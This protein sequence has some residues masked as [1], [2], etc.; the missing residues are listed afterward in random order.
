MSLVSN[1]DYKIALAIS[2]SGEDT[3]LTQ[4]SAEIDDCVKTYLGRDIET[5]TYTDEIYDGSGTNYLI[6]RQRPITAITTL[7]VYEGLDGDGV[8]DWETWTQ[9]DEYQRLIIVKEAHALYM[10]PKFPKG[11]QNLKVTYTAG[12]SAANI[13]DDIDYVCKQLMALKYMKFD[14]KLLG[15]TSVSMNVGASHADTYEVSEQNFL[16]QIEHY[17]D[18]RI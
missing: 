2:G 3:K 9:N 5:A 8:E 7:Q 4:Y 6:T 15:K 12:Y 13:P 16:K 18:L 11:D 10:E 14:K 17:R 1:A